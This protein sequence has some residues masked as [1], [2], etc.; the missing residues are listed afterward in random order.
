MS[1]EEGKLSSDV[2][3]KQEYS[4]SENTEKTPAAAQPQ[5]Q[6]KPAQEQTRTENLQRIQQRKLKIYKLPKTQKMAKLSMYSACQKCR[7][8]GWK[9]QEENRHRD[10]ES[11]YCPK[12]TEECRNPSCKHPL[13]SHI[14]HLTDITD[15]QLNELLG[16]IVD[17]ENLFISMHREVDEET[18][19]VYNYLF[20]LL[21]QCILSRQQAVIRGPLG[22][23]PFEVPSISKAVSNFLFL[24]YNHLGQAE[25]QM[26]TEVAKTFLNCLNFW[27]F[28]SPS[29]RCKELSHEDASTY[30]INYTRWLV[31]CHVPAFCNSLTHFETTQVF[32]RTLL[33]AVFKYVCYQ[34]KLKMQADKDRMP[35][36]RRSMLV[37]LPKFLDALKLELLNE[38]SPIWD[39]NFKPPVALL[40]QRKRERENNN[41]LHGHG[42]NTS[43]KKSNNEPSSSKKYKKS[44]PDGED[45]SDDVILKAIK[46][47][48]ESNYANKTELVA[49]EIAPRD[50]G[51]NRILLTIAFIN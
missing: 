33:K 35:V 17:I 29:V 28:E 39:A 31:F 41:T 43:G 12:F 20:H 46:R 51:K 34:L 22:D 30:K 4:G 1:L 2:V 23:P 19:K 38:D 21:R 40:L 32:G 13:E 49:P 7:C 36:E 10:V 24:K 15:E 3:V 18:R 11:N 42:A 14:S 44:D 37:Q 48:N 47:I 25:F 45:V 6:A 27:S 5:A 26:M 50:E 8:T 9:T 16:A